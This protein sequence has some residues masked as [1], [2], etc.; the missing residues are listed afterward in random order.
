MKSISVKS[1]LHGDISLRSCA[2]DIFVSLNEDKREVIVLDFKNVEFVSRSFA[3]EIHSK[4]GKYN[5]QFVNMNND[6]Q[7]MFKIVEN[8]KN[9]SNGKKINIKMNSP[10]FL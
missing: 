5:L 6:V 8:N 10:I 2:A 3:H 4:T 1:Y 9:F 7:K